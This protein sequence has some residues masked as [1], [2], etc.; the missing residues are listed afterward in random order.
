[1]AWKRMARLTAVS[2][3]AILVATGVAVADAWSPE[4]RAA[5]ATLESSVV[6][7]KQG[8]MRALAALYH[9][10]FAG[11]DLAQAAP[12]QREEFLRAEAELMKELKSYDCKLTPLA[13][14]VVDKTAAVQA[15]FTNTFV[16]KDGKRV[17]VSG[18]WVAALVKTERGWQFL[19]NAFLEV[20]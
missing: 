5:F 19:H 20:K 17:V 15:A 4:Q 9:E 2:V 12:L 18:R 14:Q 13:I 8:D 1:M 7:L 3:L 6:A 16:G 10:S 11:W